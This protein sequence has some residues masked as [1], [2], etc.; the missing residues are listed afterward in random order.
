MTIAGLALLYIPTIIFIVV[1]Y[2]L[3]GRL[4]V[5]NSNLMLSTVILMGL[6][7]FALF[8]TWIAYE[9][10]APALIGIVGWVT[11]IWIYF[12]TKGKE[13]QIVLAINEEMHSGNNNISADDL[14]HIEYDY[15]A[16]TIEALKSKGLISHKVVYSDYESSKSSSNETSYEDYNQ[17]EDTGDAILN[18]EKR[19]N[20]RR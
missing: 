16:S 3:I 2:G 11:T 7:I 19:H 20:L 13:N 6:S 1:T 12:V 14:Q 18:F 4:K 9:Q 10:W 17:Q 5:L 8:T 15:I